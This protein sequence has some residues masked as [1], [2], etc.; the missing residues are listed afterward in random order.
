M[1]PYNCTCDM[2]RYYAAT[3]RTTQVGYWDY[4]YNMPDQMQQYWQ[5]APQKVTVNWGEVVAGAIAG[6]IL[7]RVFK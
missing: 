2:C 7:S 1:H 5:A 4:T 3:N 6:F